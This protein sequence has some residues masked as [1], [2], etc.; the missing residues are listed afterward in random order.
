MSRFLL[1]ASDSETETLVFA[2]RETVEEITTSRAAL[3]EA[4]TWGELRSSV[5][6]HRFAELA[7]PVEAGW[8]DD[9]R[10]LVEKDRPEDWLLLRHGSMTDVFPHDVVEEFA[11]RY[12]TMMS[13][14]FNLPREL[15]SEI[16][17]ALEDRGFECREDE[18]V[19]EVFSPWE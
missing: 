18:R 6:P 12:D 10:E 17:G 1:Y 5:P 4:R 9:D 16:V 2:T 7:G 14:G 13:S 19:L 8:P 11:D 3:A 15:E